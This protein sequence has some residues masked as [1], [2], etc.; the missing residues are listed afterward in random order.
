M[1]ADYGIF[2]F[3]GLPLAL[4]FIWAVRRKT[5]LESISNDA[6]KESVDAGMIHPPSLHPVVDPLKCI[7]CKSCIHACPE[8]PA[9]QVLGIIN[10][11]ATL[12]S[13][14]DCIGHGACKKACPADAITLVFGSAER[15]IDIPDVNPDFSTNIPG[16]FIA[17]ELGGMG[18]IRNAI[19]QGCQAIN[20][21][22]KSLAETEF[23]PVTDILDVLIVGAGPAGLAATLGAKEHG[24]SYIT[25]EQSSLGGTVA[26]FPRGKIVMTSPVHLPLVGTMPLHET[27][28]EALID[29]WIKVKNDTGIE[30]QYGVRFAGIEG[31]S[32]GV[33][34]IT[35]NKKSYRTR[36]L[37]L[38]L[39]RRGT[40]RKLDIPGEDLTKVTYNFV[41]P[42]QYQGRS[43]LVVGGGD[44]ALEA[45]CTI[46][47]EESTNVTLSYR[48]GA[49]S[50]AKKKNRSRLEH[51]DA[52]GQIRVLLESNLTTIGK[53]Q[54]ELECKGKNMTITN[55]AAIICAGGIPP[56]EL[57]NDLGIT[58]E[59]RYGQV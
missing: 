30:V 35:T 39:G 54:V 16:I 3:Y 2:L 12:T 11:K 6:W 31:H 28:K 50:R 26:N 13:P 45:A 55:D 41:D 34:E 1:L 56:N 46:A 43:V 37:L 7:G 5:N 9:H 22:A 10:N 58:V 24:L 20:T 21:I 33:F 59:T 15:G 29:F 49:F 53:D 48:A 32:N 44:S 27:T 38:A 52:Q 47:E 17:G 42:Q 36:N 23:E 57:L 4:I 8:F 40:P 14:T 25:L 51:L 19:E 18:L